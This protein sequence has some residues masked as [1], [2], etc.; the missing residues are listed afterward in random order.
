MPKEY[1]LSELADAAGVSQRTIRYYIEEG[2]LPQ[3]E[4]RGP[5]TSYGPE[6]LDRLQLITELKKAFL[7]LA[8]IRERIAGLSHQEIEDLLQVADEDTPLM[9]REASKDAY[10]SARFMLH[11]DS[12]LSKAALASMTFGAAPEPKT[13]GSA[14][15]YIARLLEDRVEPPP[16]PQ[17]IPS[18]S[19]AGAD[20][21]RITLADGVELHIRQP[22]DPWT[23]KMVR[24]LLTRA[25]ELFRKHP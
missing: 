21:S 19:Q 11:S 3:P 13:R 16:T 2:L 15:E 17:P 10:Q 18:P 4:A 8:E 20:W 23:D 25:R 22:V 7:P 1:S 9:V 12:H 6:Y 5:Q 24:L 14:K